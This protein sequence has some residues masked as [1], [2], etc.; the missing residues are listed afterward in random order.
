MSRDL[1]IKMDG[2]SKGICLSLKE[3][4]YVGIVVRN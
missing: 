2:K 3:A 1:L 4:Q